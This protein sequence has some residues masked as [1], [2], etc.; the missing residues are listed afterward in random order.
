MCLD[1]GQWCAGKVCVTEILLHLLNNTVTQTSW[2]LCFRDPCLWIRLLAYISSSGACARPCARVTVHGNSYLCLLLI[3]ADDSGRI[4]CWEKYL[5]TG[6][7][8]IHRVHLTVLSLL[9]N[10]ICVNFYGVT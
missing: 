6:L 2:S 1:I 9:E 8:Q 5:Q 10:S 3:K 4:S 7:A